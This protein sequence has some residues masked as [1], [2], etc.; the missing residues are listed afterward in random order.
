MLCVYQWF[1][2]TILRDKTQDAGGQ[3]VREKDESNS[4]SKAKQ[5]FPEAPTTIGMED[6]RGGKGM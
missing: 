2:N 5:E 6:E 4:K 1:A 3:A